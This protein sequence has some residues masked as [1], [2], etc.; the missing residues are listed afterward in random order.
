[1]ISFNDAR[2]LLRLDQAARLRL[3]LHARFQTMRSRA[4]SDKVRLCVKKYGDNEKQGREFAKLMN[5]YGNVVILGNVVFT[6]P[7]KVNN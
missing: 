6:R 5:V 4:Y 1:M 7:E 3:A 2:K